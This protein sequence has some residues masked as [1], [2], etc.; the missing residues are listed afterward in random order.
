MGLYSY[1]KK[2]F[3]K[4]YSTKAPEYKEKIRAWRKGQVITELEKPVNI[5]R[6]RTLGYKAKEGYFVLRIRI[7]KGL[8]ARPSPT[9]GR[10]PRHNYKYKA[11]G[12]TYQAIAEQRVVKKY[13]LLEVLNSYWVGED[14]QYKYFE[15]ILVDPLVTGLKLSKGRAF[16]G[17]TSASKKSRALKTKQKK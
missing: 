12:Q 6:A 8:R 9:G 16:R 5:A 13:P 3:Q 2:A 1:I 11:P 4:G 17:L 7:G 15:V 10:K 14:G